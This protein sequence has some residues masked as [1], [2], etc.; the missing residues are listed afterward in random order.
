MACL[1]F[2]RRDAFRRGGLA[3]WGILAALLI[4][5]FYPIVVVL[6]GSFKTGNPGQPT[7]Y[8]L[9]GWKFALSDRNLL[10]SI[11]NTITLTVVRQTIAFLVA[12]PIAWSLARTDLPCAKWIEFL[13][14]VAFFLPTLPVLLG[15]IMLLDPEYGLINQLF[16]L[17]PFIVKGPFNIYSFWGIVWVHL[18]TNSIPFKIMLLTIAF[19]NMDASL[20]EASNVSGANNFFTFIRIVLPAMAPILSVVLLLAI[21]HSLQAF[22]I[23]L[24]LGL[25]IRFF[26]FSSLIYYLINQ[27]PPLFTAATALSCIML[28]VLIPLIAMQRWIT[29]RRN[30]ATVGGQFRPHKV[31]LGKW[32]MPGL[33]LISSVALVVTII[34]VSFLV[35]GTFMKIFGFFTIQHPW[36]TANWTRVLHDPLFGRSLWNTIKLASGAAVTSVIVSTIVAYVVVRTRFIGRGVLDFASWLPITIPGVILGLGLLSLFLGNPI[37]RAMYGTIAV[38]VIAMIVARLTTS[39]QIIK[40]NLTQLGNDIEEAARVNGGSWWQAFTNVLLP[41]IAPTLLAVGALTFVSAARDVSNVVLLATH[42]TRPLAIL[43]LDFMVDGRY[44]SGA[45]VGVILVLLT[46]GAALIGRLFGLRS[47]LHE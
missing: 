46:T 7:V 34:P 12:I 1:G 36:T 17:L 45:V 15:W 39:V 8:S 16:K 11:W 20:E 4:I 40:S 28:V 35:L 26:V 43:Q 38:M 10:L 33:F 31:R 25:P 9:D 19:R 47:G 23:E 29:V 5:V 37:L 2:L 3:H 32:K 44:E 18:V 41:L 21:I 30:Y 22:E 13:F 24:V 27:E 42:A 14:W 6:V